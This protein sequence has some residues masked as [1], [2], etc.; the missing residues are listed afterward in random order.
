MPESLPPEPI[1]S[2]GTMPNAWLEILRSALFWLMALAAL[3]YVLHSYW[4]DRPELWGKLRRCRPL[5]LLLNVLHGLWAWWRHV[6]RDLG[7]QLGRAVAR[8]R[9]W[10]PRGSQKNAQRQ[11]GRSQREEAFYHYLSTLDRA[12]E[13]GVP[14]PK[15]QTPY[16]YH[17]TLTP[18]LPE[19]QKAMT[20]LTEAFVVARYSEQ[21]ID[22]DSIAEMRDA[23]R[24]VQSALQ[25][26]AD[27]RYK[28]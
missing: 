8:L 14:R 22:A 13:V 23:A 7:T 25:I 19:A 11:K 12:Q 17:Q 21:P 26:L 16:E 20:A 5:A 1:T 2:G 10:P 27:E 28:K 3:G 9:T 24:Q 15:N 4:K 18:Q 6:R